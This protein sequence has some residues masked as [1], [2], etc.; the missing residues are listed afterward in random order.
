MWDIA[1]VEGPAFRRH[2]LR[3]RKKNCRSFDSAPARPAK[4]AG[5]KSQAGAPLRMTVLEVAVD[6]GFEI[7]GELFIESGRVLGAPHIRGFR[8]CGRRGTQSGA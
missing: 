1:A 3:S 4:E 5:R 2:H 7:A 6:D 8:M